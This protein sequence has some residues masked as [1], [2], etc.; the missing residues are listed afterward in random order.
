MNTRV[1]R[2]ASARSLPD[3]QEYSAHS[4][5]V[6]GDKS[7]VCRRSSVLLEVGSPPC[8]GLASVVESGEEESVEESVFGPASVFVVGSV[9]SVSVAGSVTESEG[10]SSVDPPVSV[11]VLVSAGSVFDV[12][13]PGSEV[14]EGSAWSVE[15]FDELAGP[16]VAVVSVAGSVEVVVVVLSSVSLP[17]ASVDSA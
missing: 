7:S 5:D 16:V 2:N 14:V 12:E 13:S 17:A 11:V 6:F 8:S 4:L 3:S 1:L 15:E 10:V 9:S